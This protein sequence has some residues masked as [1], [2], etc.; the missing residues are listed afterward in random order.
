MVFVFGTALVLTSL[1][2]I[3]CGLIGK[4]GKG[5]N[6]ET[7]AVLGELVYESESDIDLE[8]F[9]FKQTPNTD[10]GPSLI[11]FLQ[12]I[13]P[14][15]VIA[16]M[17]NGRNLQ[18]LFFAVMLGI[19]SGFIPKRKSDSLLNLL[20]G[21]YLAFSKV[22]KWAMYI[23]PIGL[24]C[25][26]AEQVSQIGVEILL[27][28]TKFVAVFSVCC[29]ILFVISTIVIWRCSGR[30][31]AAVLAGMKDT[32]IIA[33]A[34][35]SSLATIPSALD[36]MQSNLGFDKTNTNLIIPLGITICRFGSIVY[37]A[38]ATTFVAQL[39][40]AHLG[41]QGL[42]IAIIGSILAGMATS[43]ATGVLTLTMMVLVFEPLGLPVE[44]V[45]VLFIAI[46]PIVDPLRTLIIVYPACA[47]AALISGQEQYIS[48][49][50]IYFDDDSC[51]F[52]ESSGI[53]CTVLNISPFGIACVC[54]SDK[55]FK[56]DGSVLSGKLVCNDIAIGDY[57]YKIVR[58]DRL[59]DGRQKLGID[60]VNGIIEVDK[61]IPIQ[62]RLNDRKE[63]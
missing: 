29:L 38:V 9:F 5:L 11:N 33:L 53:N 21:I 18:V 6:E 3:G 62:T 36:A 22:I 34:T 63:L 23:L 43:G 42:S 30:R 19:A 41:M 60:I 45:L 13:V 48:S 61:I 25:L 40:D 55:T 12:E 50:R 56:P 49:D 31:L 8:M 2:G 15:N 35:R 20:E 44:A 47:S 58:S 32:I 4:P 59:P 26:I 52:T 54:K 24:C 16:S 46:D 17:T 51:I 28:M 27:A 39:Y 1:I 14:P 7:Q 10:A 37:F 57:S